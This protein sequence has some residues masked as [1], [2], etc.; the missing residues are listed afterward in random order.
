MPAQLSA[1][2]LNRIL[3]RWES[4]EM[5]RGVEDKALKLALKVGQKIMDLILFLLAPEVPNEEASRALG[6][7]IGALTL[8]PFKLC[9]YIGYELASG[10]MSREDG[11]P[12][13]VA[14]TEPIDSFV[15]EYI[16]TKP[17]KTL[18]N[19]ESISAITR[20]IARLT[21]EVSNDLCVLGIENFRKIGYR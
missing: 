14:A 19:Q 4:Y 13:L 17:E 8:R 21:G 3:A 5:P 11:T 12:Y 6:K 1:D 9:Y 2:D 7:A 20:E 10:N 15:L 18:A 16:A